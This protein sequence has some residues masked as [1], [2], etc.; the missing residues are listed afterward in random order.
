MSYARAHLST[1]NR[2]ELMEQELEIFQQVYELIVN[3][4]VTYSFQLAGAVIILIAGII[5]GGWVARTLASLLAKRNVDVTLR[6]FI[7]ATARLVVIILF[8]IIALSKLGISIT[9]FIAA[10]GGLA[11]GASF[12]IQGP[13]SNYGAGLVIILTRMYKVGDTI[14]VQGCSGVVRSIEL[15]TTQLVAE[16]GEDIIIPNKHIV[17]EI[18]RNSY[19]YRLVEGQIA[20]E[21]NAEPTAAIDA[22]VEVL[23]ATE[24][25]SDSSPPTVG[26]E[27]FVDAG[28]VIG[29]RYWVPT[30]RYF[31]TLY[32][33]NNRIFE[34]FASRGIRL[35]VQHHRV[36]LSERA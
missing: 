7:A 30:A 1:I 34:N 19:N 6:Q 4:V 10:I 36:D 22:I 17:G 14:S 2:R 3:F 29:Y 33:V 23:T 12:A 9:P 25:L 31:E 5:V 35:A 27:A 26:I 20:I 24:G 16:D 32:G 18:H 11:V 21:G 15:A 8:V 28:I 13:V